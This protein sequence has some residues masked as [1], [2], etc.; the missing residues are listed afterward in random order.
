MN[1]LQLTAVD[2]KTAAQTLAIDASTLQ[3]ERL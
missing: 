1:K 3:R 2:Q